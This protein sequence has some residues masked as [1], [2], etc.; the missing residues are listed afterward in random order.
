MFWVTT[1]GILP[2]STRRASARCP[3]L[4]VALR[5][6]SSLANLRRHDSRRASAEARKSPNSIGLY[7]VQMPPGERKS[8]IPDSVEM[9]A[10]VKA[11]ML[12]ASSI[13]RSRSS[14]LAICPPRRQRA[15]I[16]AISAPA[17]PQLADDTGREIVDA[18]HEQHAEP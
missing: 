6:V 9:P 5:M 2:C 8:G 4:G 7:L 3:A 17:L 16:Y 14:T 10:P 13:M 11:T 1:A 12:S 15:G 18:Q